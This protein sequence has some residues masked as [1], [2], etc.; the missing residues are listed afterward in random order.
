MDGERE[1][2]RVRGGVEGEG[3]GGGGTA[4]AK[5]QTL[6]RQRDKHHPTATN[7]NSKRPEAKTESSPDGGK[8]GWAPPQKTFARVQKVYNLHHR[9]RPERVRTAPLPSEAP[10]ARWP[11]VLDRQKYLSVLGINERNLF[12][13]PVPGAGGRPLRGPRAL[14]SSSRG[15]SPPP[16][17]RLGSLP[18][19]RAWSPPATA[20]HEHQQSDEQTKARTRCV[21]QE[22]G[23]WQK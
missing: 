13:S 9:K 22:M 10:C 21:R 14:C 4:K 7:S 6:A 11:K 3:I 20:E 2:S 16:S 18:S 23:A 1:T 12:F 19:P 15:R 5:K 17:E 8:T